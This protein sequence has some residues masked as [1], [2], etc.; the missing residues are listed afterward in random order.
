MEGPELG[1]GG[2]KLEGPNKKGS[3]VFVLYWDKVKLLLFLSL[4]HS[5]VFHPGN[6]PLLL[7][8]FP[9]FYPGKERFKKVGVIPYR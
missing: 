5:R 6:H 7:P 4:L 2:R 9:S 8:R 3:K 1:E